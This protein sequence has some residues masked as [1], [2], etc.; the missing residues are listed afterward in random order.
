MNLSK[1]VSLAEFEHS[2]TAKSKGISNAM[3]EEQIN[4]AKLL[5]E[6]IFEPIRIF[7]G[8]PITINSGFRGVALNRA[9]G[10][11]SSSQHCKGEAIDLPLTKEEF[12]FIKDSLDF[13]QL[14]A[15]YPVNGVPKWVHISY[16][17]SGNRNQ[18]LIAV[19]RGSK[20]VYLPYKGNEKLVG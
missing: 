11:A 16:K 20:T 2:N 18:V 4:N 7:R 17:S 5:C 13:D 12:F 1:H 15:E 3:N 9:I 19:K 8:K 6:K 10:G 14:I